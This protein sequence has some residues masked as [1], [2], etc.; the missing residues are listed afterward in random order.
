[1][2]KISTLI[3]GIFLMSAIAVGLSTF[4]ISYASQS[5]DPTLPN[6]NISDRLT[7]NLTSFY[8]LNDTISNVEQT[9]LS[10]NNALAAIPVL[11]QIASVTLQ[12]IGVL[13]TAWALPNFFLSI[14]SDMAK[15][16]GLPIWAGMLV[17][18]I[19][20]TSITFLLIAAIIKWEI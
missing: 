17:Q 18:A 12:G 4:Y 15:V 10:L 7:N 9:K 16:F 5:R 8:L 2:I 6:V 13:Q 11:G 14:I 3:L 20:I 19:I 1:M